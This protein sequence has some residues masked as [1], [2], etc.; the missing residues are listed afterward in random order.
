MEERIGECPGN[1]RDQ[2]EE[3]CQNIR[4]RQMNKKEVHPGELLNKTNNGAILLKV[5]S[6]YDI[7]DKIII[8]K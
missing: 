4:Q 2:R 6:F 3:N 5:K 7:I 1:L 8:S